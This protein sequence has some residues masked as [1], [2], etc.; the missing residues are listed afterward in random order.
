ME[1]SENTKNTNL[2][3][4]FMGKNLLNFIFIDLLHLMRLAASNCKRLVELNETHESN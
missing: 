2:V 3:F 4:N 1:K